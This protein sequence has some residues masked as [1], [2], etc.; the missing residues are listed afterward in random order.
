MFSFLRSCWQRRPV[1]FPAFALAAWL[2]LSVGWRPLALPDEGR[3]ASIAL[4]M[5]QSGQWT[6]PLLNGLPFFH[7]PPLFYWISGAALKVFGADPWAARMGSVV[8]A[9]LM[10]M[11]LYLFLRRYASGSLARWSLLLLAT[12][13]LFFGAAQ[14]VNLD[15]LVAG[16]ISITILA[17]AHAAMRMMQDQ[18]HGGWLWA[19][20]ALA[21]LG[22][23]AKGLIGFVLPGAVLV[24]WLLWLGQWRVLLRMLSLPGLAIFAVVGLP[25]FFLVE[26]RFS[27]L[28]HYFFIYQHF[29]RFTESGF[30]NPHPFWFY[31]PVLLLASLPW[32]IWLPAALRRWWPQRPPFAQLLQP[33]APDSPQ[34]LLR[35]WWVWLLVI[36]GFFSIP[37]SKLVGYI[38]PCLP[39]WA[40]LLT[41]SMTSLAPGEPRPWR[42]LAAAALLCLGVIAAVALRP[43]VESSRQVA[44]LLQR[45]LQPND[46]IVMLDEYEYDLPFYLARLPHRIWI[47]SD[48]TNPDLMK[49]DNWRKELLEAAA[50]DA[51]LGS[52]VL[53][54]NAQAVPRMCQALQQG[55]VWFWAN[56][57]SD[58]STRYPFLRQLTPVWSHAKGTRS[59]DGLWK[60][61]GPQARQMLG[62]S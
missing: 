29:Q 5:A 51:P 4:D 47:I 60:L 25:W 62:C 1:A 16:M 39:A 58:T 22:M 11:G 53:V 43:N 33:V 13:P 61:S 26:E 55:T 19:A 15:M 57:D 38:L 6:V 42:T 52:T 37:Q 44:P 56:L 36:V 28:F 3:Y 50:F 59:A 24:L 32:V 12:L 14:Y 17:A 54:P 9:W 23:L 2:L 10:G 8:G 35:L 21:A 31:V 34:A 18:S 27:G 49:R 46:Q 20:Y 30:N 48:W 41:Q 40:V 7:K 45:E